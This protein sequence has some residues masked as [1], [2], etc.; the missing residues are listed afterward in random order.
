M[1]G[2][3]AD[4][5]E[6]SQLRS[7]GMKCG[8]LS[9]SDGSC[10][11]QMGETIVLA[12]V[13]GPIEEQVVRRELAEKARVEVVFFV[14]QGDDEQQVTC[15]DPVS[16]KMF[17]GVLESVIQTRLFPRKLIR[18][19]VQIIND[20]GST[21]ACSLLAC[22]GALL[23]AG[24][25]MNAVPCGACCALKPNGTLLLDPTKEEESGNGVANVFVVTLGDQVLAADANGLVPR[26]LFKECVSFC[27]DANR[28]ALAFLRRSFNETTKQASGIA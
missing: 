15:R 14:G 16:E 3:R 21:A 8:L 12:S 13:F 28:A 17:R 1:S 2:D 7:L 6:G 10:R 27:S 19:T 18:V 5:R 22:T 20:G 26:A 11:F 4:G 25:E 23:D 24:I 9:R